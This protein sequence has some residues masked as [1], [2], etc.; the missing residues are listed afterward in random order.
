MVFMTTLKFATGNDNKL[1]EAQEILGIPLIKADVGDLD[2]IQTVSVEELIRHK[3]HGAYVIAG[4]PVMVEDTGLAFLSWNGLPGALI[5]WFLKS[6]DNDWILKMLEK[7]SDRRA[8][9]ICY[10][11]SY[12]WKEYQIAYGIVNGTI[13]TECRWENGFGWD[14]IFIPDGSDK[15]FAEMSSDEKNMFSMRRKAFEGFRDLFSL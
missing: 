10:V 15:T 3:A 7:F 4:E 14:K 8:E 13:S 12:D 11:A 9:A 6:V 5:K 2:E 1:R